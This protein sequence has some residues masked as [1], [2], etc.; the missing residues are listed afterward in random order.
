[1][2]FET[3]D[4]APFLVGLTNNARFGWPAAFAESIVAALP[5][6]PDAARR[7]WS[8]DGS[9]DGKAMHLE[10]EVFMEDPEAPELSFFGSAGV[11]EEIDRELSDFA[12]AKDL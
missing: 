1:M 8:V 9:F 7:R 5:D 3:G 2:S 11:I 10:I 6:L 12:E 4:I